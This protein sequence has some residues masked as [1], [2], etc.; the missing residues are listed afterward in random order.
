MPVY[1][2]EIRVFSKIKGEIDLPDNVKSEEVFKA[3][4]EKHDIPRNKGIDLTIKMK[5]D[6]HER[7]NI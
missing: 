5:D 3:L 1:V 6:N 4:R 7:N 2:Y